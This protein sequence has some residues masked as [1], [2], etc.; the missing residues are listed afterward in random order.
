[1]SLEIEDVMTGYVDIKAYHFLEKWQLGLAAA[2]RVLEYMRPDT[3]HGE[4]EYLNQDD[5]DVC[6]RAGEYEEAAQIVLGDINLDLNCSS[7]TEHIIRCV[8]NII[9]GFA[10][11]DVIKRYRPL[12]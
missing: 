5:F 2:H 11:E 10:K 8:A 3:V 4:G 7:N 6:V 9:K 12:G 1:M